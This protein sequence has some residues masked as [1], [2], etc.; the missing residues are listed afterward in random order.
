MK[1]LLFDQ[2]RAYLLATAAA[3]EKSDPRPS[4]LAI[5]IS[6][7]TG[8]GAVTIG[9]KVA[10]MLQRRQG[11]P[12]YPWAVFDRNLV[13]RVIEDHGLPA[14]LEK[15]MPEDAV[16]RVPDLLE[17]LFG[18][19]PPSSTLVH[20]ATRTILRLALL[21]N[22]VL[23]GR[24]A[25]FVTARLDHVLHVRLVAPL[26]AR[27]KNVE[28]YYDLTPHEAA[29]F[30]AK[31]DRGRAG[32]VRRHFKADIE[33]PLHYHLTINTGLTGFAKAAKIIAEAARELGSG[34]S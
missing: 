3:S 15:Y 31:G 25:N 28:K 16:A 29:V 11:A 4:P 10:E 34:R 33:D 12:R 17:D 30:V 26:E 20:Y 23:I 19:H 7:Q 9:R 21:G 8:A 1:P 22:V 14:E 13:A 27:I 6:R 18:L 2:C 32:Y 24:G 5:T